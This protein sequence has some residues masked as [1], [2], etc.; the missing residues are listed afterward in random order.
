MIRTTH[1]SALI[2]IFCL[3]LFTLP[4]AQAAAPPIPFS[5]LLNGFEDCVANGLS[6]AACCL[7]A[8]DVYCNPPAPADIENCAAMPKVC[9][10]ITLVEIVAEITKKPA[11][12]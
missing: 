5:P 10:L 2:L 3:G 1:F 6:P 9:A 11:T 4:R 7:K 8:Y 12:E